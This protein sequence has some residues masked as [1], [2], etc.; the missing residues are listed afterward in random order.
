MNKEDKELLFSEFVDYLEEKDAI[1]VFDGPQMATVKLKDNTYRKKT[2]GA[3][4]F[5]LI[6][7]YQGKKDIVFVFDFEEIGINE[8]NALSCIEVTSKDMDGSFPLFLEEAQEWAR[9]RYVERDASRLV[10]IS[11]AES[12]KALF[13]MITN[14]EDSDRGLVEQEATDRLTQLPTFGMF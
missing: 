2:I 12:V 3:D 5:F 6:E 10:A 9:Q 8:R 4:S 14:F 1:F 13:H 11:E 7:I